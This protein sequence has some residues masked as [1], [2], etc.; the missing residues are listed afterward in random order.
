MC[1]ED[2]GCQERGERW[3]V[4]GHNRISLKTVKG[5]WSICPKELTDEKK[6][7]IYNQPGDIKQVATEL[8]IGRTPS[9]NEG[10]LQQL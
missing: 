1:D 5:N 8:S 9:M 4:E 6:I 3:K 2:K 10:K 7:T